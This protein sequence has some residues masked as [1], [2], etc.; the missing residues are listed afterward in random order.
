MSIRPTVEWEPFLDARANLFLWEAFVTGL[1]KGLS[2]HGDAEIAAMS[3]SGEV[4]HIAEA[5]SVTAE[6]PYSLIGAALLRS[7]LST[8]VGLLFS[9]CV[10]IRS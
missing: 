7:G 3:F 9:Q 4:P 2:H 6:N 10:V 5:N 8:D 1:A